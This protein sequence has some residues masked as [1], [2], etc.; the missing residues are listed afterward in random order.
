M[1]RLQINKLLILLFIIAIIISSCRDV[2][3]PKPLGYYRIDLPA[4]DYIKLNDSLANAH[5]LPV[6]FEYPSYG[7]LSFEQ[8]NYSGPGWFNISFPHYKAKIYLTYLGIK[9]DLEEL[10]EQTYKLNVK[11]HIIKADAINEQI[12]SDPQ[13]NIYGILYDLKGNTATAVQFFMTDSIK[14]YLRGSLYFSSAPNADSLAPVIGFFRDD[15]IHLINT[16]E[17]K[18][19]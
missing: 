19:K 1:T 18:N 14:H 4:H 12:I 11:N 8:D 17:W 3:V 5:N 6:S 13:K 7:K 10:M 9:N 2:A 16:L 15:I